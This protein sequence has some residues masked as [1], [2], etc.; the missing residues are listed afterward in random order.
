MSKP[1][2]W[3]NSVKL[4]KKFT[5]DESWAEFHVNEDLQMV[6]FIYSV[7]I[8][9]STFQC[10]ESVTFDVLDSDFP[11]DYIFEMIHESFRF[12]IEDYVEMLHT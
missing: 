5:T 7:K 12:S 6:T 2:W 11:L 10:E 8:S 9:G 1:L 4:I 3:K